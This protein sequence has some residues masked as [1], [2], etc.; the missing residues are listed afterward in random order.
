MD[1]FLAVELIVL[2][3]FINKM[4]PK[5]YNAEFLI[6]HVL[7]IAAFPFVGTRWHSAIAHAHK[8]LTEG[9]IKQA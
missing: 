5:I 2:K 4:V 3:K 8:S 1:S 7:K 9:F 6:S